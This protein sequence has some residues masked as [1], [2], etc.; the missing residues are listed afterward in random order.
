MAAARPVTSSRSGRGRPSAADVRQRRQ[1][2]LAATA[3]LLA[4]KGFRG[5]TTTAIAERAG[6]SKESLYSWFGDKNALVA[7]LVEAN[8]ARMNQQ[9]DH[10]LAREGAVQHTLEAFA[11]HLLTLLVSP[12]SIA[13]NR[14]AIAELPGSAVMA[15]ALLEHG[16]RSSGALAERY[17]A[18]CMERDLLPRADPARAF[19]LLYG[20]TVQDTQIR[21]LLGEAA[22]DAEAIERQAAHAVR[23]FVHLLEVEA[24]L[25]P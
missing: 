22:P 16:R 6:V 10:G 21:C 5:A 8:A 2:V 15:Q 18:D 17:L 9:I 12:T 4:A 11:G 23:R 24:G 20:L 25:S 13:I 3:E 1:A 19:E 7:A 14:A